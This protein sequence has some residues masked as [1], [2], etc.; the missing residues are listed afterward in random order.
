MTFRRYLGNEGLQ[1]MDPSKLRRGGPHRRERRQQDQPAAT[2]SYEEAL[3]ARASALSM[4]MW[5]LAR[6][7]VASSMPFQ[8]LPTR[9]KHSADLAKVTTSPIHRHHEVPPL[10]SPFRRHSPQVRAPWYSMVSHFEAPTRCSPSVRPCTATLPTSSVDGVSEW[11]T[12]TQLSS[13][14]ALA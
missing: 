10:N 5:T 11:S 9:V 13:S 3:R 8:L 4:M 12:R 1:H 7:S 14:C 6:P 2:S